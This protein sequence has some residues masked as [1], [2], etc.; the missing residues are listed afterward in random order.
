MVLTLR[1]YDLTKS[2]TWVAALLVADFLPIVVI[3]LALGPLIDRLPRRRLMVA[4]DLARCAVFCALPF[5]ERPG[6]IVALAAVSGIATAF[7]RPAVYA[8]LPNLVEG[9]DDLTEANSLLG[10]AENISW[11]VGPI[12]A[13]TVYKFAGATPA[14]LLNAATFLF[15][16]SFVVRIPAARLQAEGRLTR[17]H[18]RD[19][20]DGIGLVLRTPQLR[21]VL[22][23]WNVVIAGNA[24]LN[25][26]EVF[27]AQGSLDAGKLGYAGL[28]AATGAGLVLG[29]LA[30]PLVMGRVGLRRLYPAAILVMAIGALLASR[31]PSIWVAAPLA[32]FMTVGNAAAI[33]CNQLLVQ[34]GAPDAMRGRAIAVLMSSTY[35]TL[36]VGMAV[37]GPLTNEYGGRALWAGA[38]ALYLAASVVA[39]VLVAVLPHS[40]EQEIPAAT[41]APA[42]DEPEPAHAGPTQ[43]EPAH[44]GPTRANG[45]PTPVYARAM[46]DASFPPRGAQSPF[47]RIRSLLDEV[48]QTHEAE[49]ERARAGRAGTP[50]HA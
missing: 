19:V 7:F 15:S 16:A 31:A 48:D 25:V 34:R 26:A 13:G 50:G 18:W 21:T 30:T 10:A 39:A 3:G 14:Y 42:V 49:A 37:T 4:S 47:E 40:A 45:S 33:V 8:G 2:G 27:F 20:A 41:D 11:M 23:V 32:A 35:V 36:A 29:S 28:V 17:G 43:A 9:D 12:I 1:V 38:G 44:T 5:V 24:A 22:I 6:G 46:A